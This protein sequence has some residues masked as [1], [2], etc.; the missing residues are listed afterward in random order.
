MVKKIID[1]S[2][3]I[4]HNNIIFVEEIEKSQIDNWGKYSF[5]EN[6]MTGETVEILDKDYWKS[7]ELMRALLENN[8]WGPGPNLKKILIVWAILISVIVIIFVL[9]PTKK[10]E[11][12]IPKVENVYDQN[13]STT[14]VVVDKIEKPITIN[15][16]WSIT[17]TWIISEDQKIKNEIEIQKKE[18]ESLKNEIALSKLQLDNQ[19][20]NDN[21]IY[22]NWVF[23]KQV[24]ELSTENEKIKTENLLLID[25]NKDLENKN[26]EL[27]IENN[28]FKLVNNSNDFIFFLWNKIFEQCEK[29]KSDYCKNLYFWY[30]KKW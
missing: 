27:I 30:I 3:I 12:I 29:I 21:L 15:N 14:T 24:N 1:R 22:D 28:E 16:T 19:K 25:K 10:E 13:K 26:K 17:N 4:S 5:W 11:K 23:Q 8:S 7:S 2:F 20:V 9:I 6:P 18:L